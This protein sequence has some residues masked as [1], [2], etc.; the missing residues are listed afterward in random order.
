MTAARARCSRATPA[1][2][3]AIDWMH[4]APDGADAGY[5]A[6]KIV[7]HVEPSRWLTALQRVPAD[8][9]EA[10]ELCLRG[11]AARTRNA[12][13]ARAEGRAVPFGEFAEAEA[14]R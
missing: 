11:F 12:R 14:E 9:R 1:A 10:V 5:L 6:V 3:R 8:R 4:D 13:R 2:S 7:R